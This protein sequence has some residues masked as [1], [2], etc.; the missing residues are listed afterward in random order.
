MMK[1]SIQM[2]LLTAQQEIM[3]IFRCQ[4]GNFDLGGNDFGVLTYA[5]ALE[6]LESDFY[7]KVVN[8]TGSSTFNDIEKKC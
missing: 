5:Y 4:N 3:D 2:I 6:Q 8:A 7:Y 1:K